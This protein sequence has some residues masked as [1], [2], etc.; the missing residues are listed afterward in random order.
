MDAVLLEQKLGLEVIELQADAARLVPAEKVHVLVGLTVA[1]AFED[2]FQPPR[3]IGVFLGGL[4][5]VP[6]Q[7][8][9]AAVRVCGLGDPRGAVGR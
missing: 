9:A 1:R 7:R 8:L 5:L 4:G 2:G 3:S 6:G